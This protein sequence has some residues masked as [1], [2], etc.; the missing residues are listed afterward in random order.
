MTQPFLRF[1]DRG[2]LITGGATGIGRATALAFAEHGAAVTLGDVDARG[3]AET[4]DSIRSRG[5][6]A[7]FIETDVSQARAVQAL[8]AGAVERFGRIDCAFNNAGVLP[9]TLSITETDEAD[10]DRIIAVDLKGVFLCLK[11]QIAAML[12]G[13]GGAI[14]NTASV[15]GVIADPGMGA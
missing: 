3:A 12:V 8:V 14:V 2:V 6:Q 11:Y 15:A 13:G 4:V 1:K 7:L 5:G 9:P 10:F